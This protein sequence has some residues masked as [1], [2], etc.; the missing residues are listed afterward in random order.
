[1]VKTGLK[2][3]RSATDGKGVNANRGDG[4]ATM[5]NADMAQQQAVAYLRVS[6]ARQGES[7][8]G[9]EAQERSVRELAQSRGWHIVDTY[10][11]VESGKRNDRPDLA[12]AL[13]RARELGAVLVVS[14]LDRL[15]RNVAFLAALIE[16]G[17]EVRFA[18]LPDAD[19]LTVHVLAAVAE[20]EARSISARTR[21]A[22]ASCRARG[23]KLGSPCPER[24]ARAAGVVSKAKANEH[25]MKIEPVLRHVLNELSGASLGRL[26]QELECR[27]VPTSRGGAWTA[28][29]V[30][31]VL[32][33]LRLRWDLC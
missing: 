26:A 22:L 11:E 24:G 13:D 2:F 14:R 31:R 7:G 33:R 1:M 29:A 9:L 10:T 25:A 6:T 17:V 28:K 21:A 12:A 18:D 19:R 32:E 15:S 20:A 5:G 16:S 4:N 30:S 8:L 27:R 23:V 3:A